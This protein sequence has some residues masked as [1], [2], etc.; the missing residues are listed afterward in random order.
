[1]GIK[2][3]LLV[4][5][6]VLALCFTLAAENLEKTQKKDFIRIEKQ[7]YGS[8]PRLRIKDLGDARELLQNETYFRNAA[9]RLVGRGVLDIRPSWGGW[10]GA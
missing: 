10:L 3:I 6:F 5:V 9:F 4:F 8:Q 1:M 7:F 2:A